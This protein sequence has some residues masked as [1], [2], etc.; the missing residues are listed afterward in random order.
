MS[1]VTIDRSK[2]LGFRLLVDSSNA[3]EQVTLG[4]KIGAP[5]PQKADKPET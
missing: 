4:A 3:S 5:K 2:L 1:N